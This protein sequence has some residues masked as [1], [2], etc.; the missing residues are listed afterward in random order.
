MPFGRK[1]YFIRMVWGISDYKLYYFVR[2]IQRDILR[3]LFNN[4]YNIVDV[5]SIS[6]NLPSLIKYRKTAK[7]NCIIDVFYKYGYTGN[8]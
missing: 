6:S 7:E 5:H 1:F 3:E 2:C 4:N 8:V